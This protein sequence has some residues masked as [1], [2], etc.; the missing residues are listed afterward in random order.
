LLRDLDKAENQINKLDLKLIQSNGDMVPA[1]VEFSKAIYDGEPCTLVLIRA[2][3]DT[4]ELEEQITYL[5]Q[6]DLIT[7]LY[8]RQ[9]FMGQL[10]SSITQAVNS[11][12]QSAVVYFAIDNFQSI[13]DMVGISG[14]DILISDI[15]KL[16]SENVTAGQIVARFGAASYACLGIVS[17]KSLVKEFATSILRL[18]EERVFEIGDQSI[19]ATC[20]ASICFIDENSPDN[21]NRIIARAEKTCDLIQIRG[22][23]R[24]RTYIPK[25]GEMTRKEADGVTTVLI[26]DALSH[27]R[28][29]GLYQ[30][31][32]S[33]K[34]AN[35]ERYI[36]SLE[37]SSEDGRKFYEK[38]YRRTAERSGMAQTLDRWII[39]HAIKKTAEINRS[40]RKV[41]F[42]IPLSVGSVLDKSLAAWISDS[43]DKAG[44]PGKQL[45]FMVNEAHAVK[46]LKAAKTLF[47]GLRAIN[48]QIG[49]DNFG[50]GNNPFQLVKHFHA[51]Y[52]RIDAAYMDKLSRNEGNQEI[53]R[54]FASQAASMKIRSITPGVEDADIL[55]VL[56]SLGVDFV[57]GDFLQ[58]SEQVLNY[59]FSSLTG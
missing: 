44:V 23:N 8:N 47:S 35:G 39:L 46:H 10:K 13:R 6:H 52:I 55:S 57:Q 51:D 48:C 49:L 56:W 41:E 12:N 14:C 37:L 28:I 19:S 4:T 18:V 45:I 26:K 2:V 59:D 24:S 34:A 15:A 38:N 36:S 32:V 42:F 27:D 58:R 17:E 20:S 33:I 31:I 30:P 3:V 11:I 7:G 54:D 22:G 40:S 43:L 53:I 21:A 5:H 1:T 16:I 9:N 50:A 29:A 25:A